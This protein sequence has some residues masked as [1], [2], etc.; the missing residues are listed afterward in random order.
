MLETV[1][2][3]TDCM[4]Q[5]LEKAKAALTKAKEEYMMYYNH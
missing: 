4:V 3:F 2:D 1:N 5:G